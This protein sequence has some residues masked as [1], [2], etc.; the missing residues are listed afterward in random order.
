MVPVGYYTKVNKFSLILV[1]DKKVTINGL[2]A[3]NLPFLGPDNY[4]DLLFSSDVGIEVCVRSLGSIVY[5]Y[6]RKEDFAE[7]S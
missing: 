1:T 3:S 7:V 2:L 5:Y 4:E 6:I